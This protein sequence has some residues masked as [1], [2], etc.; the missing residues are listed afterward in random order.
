MS[1][2]KSACY[3]VSL[4]QFLLISSIFLILHNE[5]VLISVE[6]NTYAHSSIPESVRTLLHGLQVWPL[7]LWKIQE[8]TWV[9]VTCDT[10]KHF[11]SPMGS[12]IFLL[13]STLPTKGENEEDTLGSSAPGCIHPF[14][15]LTLK[16]GLCVIGWWPFPK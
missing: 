10:D 11:P 8:Q 14:L 4:V 7:E 2:Y 5:C 16:D 1:Y 15:G 6:E 12:S 9:P 13:P 3:W